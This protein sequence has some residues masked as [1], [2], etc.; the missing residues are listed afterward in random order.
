MFSNGKYSDISVSNN[1]DLKTIM[2]TVFNILQEFLNEFPQSIVTFKGSDFRRQ[3]L[4]RIIIS[5]ELE[6]I[7][8]YYF[9]FGTI[10]DKIIE[11]EKNKDYE[12][13]IIRKK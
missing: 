5:R 6:L 9:V 13:F 10:D 11:F 2:A 1:D 12:L 3:R 8:K 4:Y 7:K